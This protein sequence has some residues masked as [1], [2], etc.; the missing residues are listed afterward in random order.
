[1]HRPLLIAA[2]LIALPGCG[3]EK[4][5]VVEEDS[6]GPQIATS[7]DDVALPVDRSDQITS[8][9]ATTGDAAGMPKDGGAVIRTP[10]PEARPT[11]EAGRDTPAT[12]VAA[13]AVAA[14]PP[15]VTPP[16]PPAPPTAGQ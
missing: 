14:P 10:K 15:M 9:D 1:M 5:A 13:P 6:G 16:P 7:I 11:V 2:L 3:K 12:P 8:I 4:P